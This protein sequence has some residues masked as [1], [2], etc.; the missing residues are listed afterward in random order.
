MNQKLN[1]TNTIHS[2]VINYSSKINRF[3]IK[4]SYGIVFSLT[5]TTRGLQ[6]NLQPVDEAH[7]VPWEGTRYHYMSAKLLAPLAI[8]SFLG[9]L[10]K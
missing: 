8:D 1:I 2:S 5:D 9:K 6:M 7:E 3:I 10:F 4:I